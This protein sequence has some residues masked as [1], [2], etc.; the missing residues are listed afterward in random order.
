LLSRKIK[1]VR[2]LIITQER[3]VLLLT[4][5]LLGFLFLGEDWVRVT[6]LTS[7]CPASSRQELLL[8]CLLI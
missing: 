7:C 5:L 4:L 6:L 1:V 3:I 2:V 8:C